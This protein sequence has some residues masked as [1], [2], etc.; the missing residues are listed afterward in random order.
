MRGHRRDRVPVVER[1]LERLDRGTGVA[2]LVEAADQL[3][4]FAAEHAAAD[5]VEAARRLI[6]PDFLEGP[7]PRLRTVVTAADGEKALRRPVHRKETLRPAGEVAAA[8]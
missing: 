8:R 4:R 1:G 2:R 7:R 5:Q 6:E 3:L